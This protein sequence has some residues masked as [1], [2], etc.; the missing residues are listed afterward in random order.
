VE[1]R[2]IDVNLSA[3]DNRLELN[4]AAGA[5]A[6]GSRKDARS[7]LHPRHAEMRDEIRTTHAMRLGFRQVKGLREEDIAQLV[8][9]RGPGYDSVRAVWLRAGISSAVIERLA[10]AD[11]FRSLGLDRR[12][13]L[14]AARGLNRVGGQEDAPLLAVAASPTHEPDFALPSMLPGEHVVEDYRSFGLSLKAHPAGLLRQDLAARGVVQADSLRTIA[15][16]ARVRVAG[17]VLVRQRPGTASGVIFMTLEDETG[18][19]NIVVW[20]KVFDR[21]RPQ[22]LGAR[23]CAVDGTVQS[24]SGVIHVIAEKLH[25]WNGLTARLS[26]LELDPPL[27]HADEVRRP[28]HDMRGH[29]RNVRFD[30]RPPENENVMPKGRNFH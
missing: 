10:D 7:F 19:A 6:A 28:G 13:A 26:S 29:P 12:A 9:H 18:I 3:W 25:D 24:E 8:A 1:V 4:D 23:L 20:P 11:A 17:L 30:L 27:A 2:P 21:F 5:S 15:N 22:V 16:G 14:W